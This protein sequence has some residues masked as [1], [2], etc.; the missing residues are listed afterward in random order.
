MDG[1]IGDWHDVL[2]L[3]GCFDVSVDLVDVV[4][5]VRLVDEVTVRPVKLQDWVHFVPVLLYVLSN[6]FLNV[7]LAFF[8]LPFFQGTNTTFFHLFLCQLYVDV[9][10]E[11]YSLVL[12]DHFGESLCVSL[13]SREALN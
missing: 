4:V 6:F 3:K 11:F 5:G 12:T 2:F 8:F 10:H 1:Y 13:I 7:L 9:P